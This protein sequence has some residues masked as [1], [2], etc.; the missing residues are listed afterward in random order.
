MKNLFIVFGFI[1][2][3]VSSSCKRDELTIVGPAICPEET[4][5]VTGKGLKLLPDTI[6]FTVATNK[7]L[8]F[9][10]TLSQ[11][12]DWTVTIEGVDSKAKKVFKG[13]GSIVSVDWAG[14][15][16]SAVFFQK[17]K[18]NITLSAPCFP[19]V[20]IKSINITAISDFSAI[21]YVLWNF[22]KSTTALSVYGDED[23]TSHGLYNFP[24]AP[25][26]VVPSPQGG[27]Y[28][29]FSAGPYAQPVW[30][31]GALNGGA[32]GPALPSA[33]V[34]NI[35]AKTSSDASRVYFN[36]FANT[37]GKRMTQIYIQAKERVGTTN[38]I[39]AKGYDGS[40][41]GWQYFSVKLS[42]LKIVNVA[43]LKE[44]NIYIQSSP[45][46]SKEGELNLDLPIFTLD[47]PF[48]N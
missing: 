43:N 4:F 18:C 12:V 20:A 21:G 10:D 24:A 3:L 42:D 36:F 37:N 33:T 16:G 8:S 29:S 30:Y 26:P 17:E 23:T 28:F 35:V 27:G 5:H 47:K 48:L 38:V 32:S 45:A 41:D 44:F 1:I 46:Q 6:N 9:N 7:K 40:F 22:D 39:R 25:G 19:V 15:P 14:E 13:N 2:V 34:A 11:P 31:F